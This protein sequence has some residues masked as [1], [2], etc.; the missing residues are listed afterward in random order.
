M[1]RFLDRGKHVP[2]LKRNVGVPEMGWNEDV[3]S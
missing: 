1:S 2:Y 3:L